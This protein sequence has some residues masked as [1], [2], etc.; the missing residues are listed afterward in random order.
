M[1]DL[2]PCVDRLS[3]LPVDI[4]LAIL[5]KLGSAREAVRLSVL[6]RRWAKLPYLLPEPEISITE[7]LP[8]ETQLHELRDAQLSRATESFCQAVSSFTST[9]TKTRCLKLEFFLVHGC[10]NFLEFFLVHKVGALQLAIRTTVPEEECDEKL[11]FRY[12]WRFHRFV[13]GPG[14][15]AGAQEPLVRQRRPRRRPGRVPAATGTRAAV[16]GR[17]W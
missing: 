17:G 15:E 4:L 1:D 13:P 10:T 5:E 9:E 3:A 14:H 11:M 12:A 6:S 7:F 16:Q 8:A 2:L